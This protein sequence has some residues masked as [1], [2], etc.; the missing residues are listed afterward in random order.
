VKDKKLTSYDFNFLSIEHTQKKAD[1]NLHFNFEF[2]DSEH[3]R[4]GSKQYG[5][6]SGFY[7]HLD[8]RQSKEEISKIIDSL[9]EES[10]IDKETKQIAVLFNIQD[11]IHKA[12]YSFIGIYNTPV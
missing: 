2:V 4:I 12:Y 10:W 5:E 1:S 9:Y 7:F 3:L 8:S 6:L 11:S